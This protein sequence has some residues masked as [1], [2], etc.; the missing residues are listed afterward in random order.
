MSGRP[1]I[2]VAAGG[3]GGHL[4]P[5]ESL[6]VALARRDVRIA[7]ASD[8]RVG[9]ISASFPAETVVKIPAATPSG[10][11]PVQRARAAL[12][13][14]LGTLRALQALRRLRPDAVIGFGGY[15]TVPPL[16]AASLL[17]I[18]TV[19]HEQNG[20]IGRANRFLAPRVSLIATGFA[21]VRGVPATAARMVHTGNPVRPAVLA[22]AQ[23]PYPAAL[24][25]GSVKLLVFG[26]SQ[27]ARVMS[28]I[29]PA[30]I[31]QVPDELRR[32]LVI[33]QQARQED[34]ARVRQAYAALGVA[35]DVQSFFK[36]LPQR[37]A[38]A[39]LVVSRSGASTVAE[40]SVVGRPAILVPL[41]GALDQDQAANA[42]SLAAIGAATMINQDAFT[43]E[44]LAGELIDYL[45]NPENLTRAAAAAKSAGINDAAERLAAEVVRLAAARPSDENRP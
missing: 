20:V 17:R 39:H 44:R 5:A 9:D 2:L 43:P 40:L 38:D 31:A 13:L 16:I 41:P 37:M 15:P 12:V 32:R 21:Q 35:A 4:F 8:D 11:S 25:D 10:G 28:D 23:V 33:T 1:L 14:G 45:K 34:L 7:L 22:A 19:I 42:Q 18:P 6:A 29:V 3:T 36:D 27:G 26:G 24:P 30:A